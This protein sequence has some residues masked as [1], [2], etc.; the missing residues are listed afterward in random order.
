MTAPNVDDEWSGEIFPAVAAADDL[1][2]R[3]GVG[4]GGVVSFLGTPLIFIM[5]LLVL[6][7]LLLSRSF[8]LLVL[9]ILAPLVYS[10]S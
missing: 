10:F 1:L 5:L 2:F 7:L 4:V 9:Y 3:R 8:D 6:I